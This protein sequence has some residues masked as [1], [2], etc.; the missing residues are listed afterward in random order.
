[1]SIRLKNK[2]ELR[3]RIFTMEQLENKKFSV[4]EYF[5]NSNPVILDAGCG[6]GEFLLDHAKMNPQLN[7]VG[8]DYSWK[9]CLFSQKKM[10]LHELENVIII[11]AAFEE[12]FVSFFEAET[13]IRI[14]MNFPDPWPKT[15]HHKRRSLQ[16]GLVAEFV[17]M[18][19]PK[20]DFYFVTD[21]KD[22]AVYAYPIIENNTALINMLAEKQIANELDGYFR[23]LFCS[24]AEDRGE[25]INYI[26]F[27]KQH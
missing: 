14:H 19:K 10:H 6:K 4:E 3:Q 2:E 11:R 26:W 1:M 25:K 13:F 24:K 20:G 12:I 22:Y 16:I 21:S 27:Q 5:G 15:K 18:L 7:Y 9:K 17:R 8:V 23:T